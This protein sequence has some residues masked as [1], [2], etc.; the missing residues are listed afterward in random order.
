VKFLPLIWAG[1]WRKPVRTALTMLSLVFAFMLFGMLRSV[2]AG[3][4]TLI[5]NAEDNRIFIQP[6]FFPQTLP[7]SYVDQIAKMEGVTEVGYQSFVNGYYRDQKTF[8]YVGAASSNM[9][10]IYDELEVSKEAREALRAK[11]NGILLS[12]WMADHLGG[13]KIGDHVPVHSNDLRLKDGSQD[14]DF[15]V[16]GF[17]DRRDSPGVFS[18]SFGNFDYFN[19]ARAEPR[20]SVSQIGIHIADPEKGLQTARAIDAMFLNS[21]TPTRSSVD[22]IGFESGIAS[23]GNIK[24]IVNGIMTAVLFVLL[25]LTAT[26]LAQS[27]DERLGEFAVL[28]TLGFSDPSVFSFIVFESL[29]QSAVGAA[30]GLAASAIVAPLMQGKLPGPPVFFRVPTFVFVLGALTAL[31]VAVAAAAIPAWRVWRLQIVDALAKR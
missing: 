17:L 12:P 14:W 4:D 27:V 16:V 20:N 29:V 8:H 18:F 11:P 31:V 13:V 7:L 30:L 26:T 19:E 10:N 28:K 2:D 23:L 21:G 3:F 22:R 6:R 24:L 1:V 25:V 9:L 5:A 15:E